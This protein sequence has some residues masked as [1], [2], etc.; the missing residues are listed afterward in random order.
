M[1]LFWEMITVAQFVKAGAGRR[2]PSETGASAVEYSFLVAAIAAL[3][4]VLLFSIGTF[5]GALFDDTCSSIA[6]GEY[7]ATPTSC[8]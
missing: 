7:S 5:T 3:L 6:Q 8:P 2:C 1:P 4:V